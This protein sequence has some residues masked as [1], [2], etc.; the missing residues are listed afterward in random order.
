MTQLNQTGKPNQ[1]SP[2]F[3]LIKQFN[4]IPAEQHA[5]RIF[6]LQLI[7]Y[8]LKGLCFDLNFCEWLNE[9]PTTEGSWESLLTEYESRQTPHSF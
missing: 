4:L 9:P 1:R 8:Y 3:K 5:R 7:E 6:H 2:L